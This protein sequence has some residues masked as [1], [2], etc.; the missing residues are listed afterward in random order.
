MLDRSVSM[1]SKR[2]ELLQARARLKKLAAKIPPSVRPFVQ[3][4]LEPGLW[5][6]EGPTFA[7]Y[8]QAR[9]FETR[10]DALIGF[11]LGRIFAEACK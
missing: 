2:E 7:A 4:A 1:A 6:E 3:L 11:D 8:L 5:P 9:P 10:C